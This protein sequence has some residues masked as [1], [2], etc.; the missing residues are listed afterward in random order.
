MKAMT[1]MVNKKIGVVM[2]PITDINPEKD[3]TFAMLLEAQKRK[4]SIYYFEPKDLYIEQQDA[5]GDARCL[6]VADVKDKWYTFEGPQESIPLSKLDVIL[7][8]KDPPFT[9]DYIYIT[10]LLSLA[11]KQGCLVINKPQS[12]RDK[13]EKLFVCEFPE[14]TPATLVSSNVSKL[15]AFIYKHLDVIVKPL[16]GMGG[17]GVARIQS[18]DAETLSILKT[19]TKDGAEYIMAQKYIPEIKHGDKRIL[20]V[21][22]KPIPYALARIPKP[23]D[24]R[25]N[26]AAGATGKGIPISERDR[27]ICDKV[28]PVLAQK[29]LWFVGLDIIGDYLT[30]I[31]VT[32]P[33][34]IRELDR[35]FNIN[36]AGTL[37]DW[38][39]SHR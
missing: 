19:M 1:G 4:W 2:D 30:E 38:I 8:R 12:L 31:N 14:L 3:G 13:N 6:S 17:T 16:S 20:L 22:G 29:G 24:I 9:I 34:C 37:F 33:T 5:M 28:G 15:Q 39:E 36:I 35:A 26:I 27:Y 18:N 7:M 32:S 10:Q 21:N 25:G 23:G 11:E